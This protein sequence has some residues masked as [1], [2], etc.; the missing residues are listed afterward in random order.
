MLTYSTYGQYLPSIKSYLGDPCAS[1]L[2]MAQDGPLAVY[3]APFEWVN[4]HARVVLVGIT[5][6][7]TQAANA[8]AEA[9]RVMLERVSDTE[10]LRR[11]KATGAFSGAMRPNLVSLLDTVG[12]HTWLGLNTCQD[13]FERSSGLLQTASVLQFPVFLDGKNYN[14]TPDPLKH[15]LLR[16]MVVQHFGQTCARLSEAVFVPLGAVPTRVLAWLTSQGLLAQNRVLDGLPHPS[17]ANAERIKYFLGQKT[18]SDLSAKTDPNR[19]DAAKAALICA[20]ASFPKTT[21]A[22]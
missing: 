22:S 6:G 1:N 17:G 11:A 13:L 16:E 2:L 4:P 15:P 18:R 5:P 9:K 20:V 7:K 14:G 12:L 8:L 21:R 3:Y 19:L 10:V